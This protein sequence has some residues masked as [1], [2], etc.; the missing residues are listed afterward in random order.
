MLRKG[1]LFVVCNLVLLFLL[2]SISFA[3]EFHYNNF[4]IGD[5]A[6]GMGGAYTAI[7]DDPSGLYY[8]P[9]GVVYA[10]GKNLSASVN[11]YY[12]KSKKY[13]SVIGGEG[14]ERNSSSLLPNFFGITQPL[15]SFTFG[16]SYAVPDS[17]LENQSQVLN[18]SFAT[19]LGSP[20]TRYIIN[21]NNEDTTYNF[22]PSLAYEV[23]SK[24]S[25][26]GTLYLYHRSNQTILNQN[27]LLQDGRTEWSN[28][29]INIV[30]RGY[31]PILGVIW[32]PADKW[33][34]G[35]SLAKTFVYSESANS[36]VTFKAA[37]A[38]P[39]NDVVTSFSSV[40]AR[41]RFPLEIRTG[42]A[43]FASS[44]LIVSA[45][46]SYYTK[47]TDPNFGDRISVLNGAI[48][49]EY[50]ID[51][52]WAV[53]GGLFSNLANTPA[54]QSDHVNQDEKVNIYGVSASVSSFNRNTSIT[55]GTNYTT[56]KGQAQIL[57]NSTDIQNVTETG[58]MLFL[59]S[60][61]SY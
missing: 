55:L 35:V 28:Q 60:S 47:V 27:I 31:R 12:N 14:W 30:E 1:A 20:A 54:L 41:R 8:N 36:Q 21:F 10:T 25:V 51:K 16:F 7:A 43:Y 59:S 56:G 29:Y 45:D 32:S 2:C 9:A 52:N 6:S 42:V 18:G 19:T 23:N 58:W 13:D 11:A 15:G 5:R 39:P 26:G 3:D 50:Y 37:N 24:F 4:L 48:G 22:G 53:R 34:V 40:D 61:Y 17:M 46:G 44:S 33:T 49:T 38:V 57:G